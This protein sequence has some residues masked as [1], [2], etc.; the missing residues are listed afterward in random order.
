MLSLEEKLWKDILEI[1]EKH[2]EIGKEYMKKIG[3]DT[4]PTLLVF[5]YCRSCQEM[6]VACL[7]MMVDTNLVRRDFKVILGKAIRGQMYCPDCE[8]LTIPLGYSWNTLAWV[9]KAKKSEKKVL[10]EYYKVMG[11]IKNHP[12]KEEHYLSCTVTTL[13]RNK[14]ATCEIVRV[15]GKIS[16]FKEDIETLKVGKGRFVI[17][18]PKIRLSD[19]GEFLGWEK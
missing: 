5:S 17:K 13:G 11:S 7:V 2:R 10:D 9:L 3:D 1:V 8:S 19:D 4:P 12:L 16:S 14:M 18:L 6:N 15:E